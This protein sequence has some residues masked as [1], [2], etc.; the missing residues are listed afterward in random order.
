MYISKLKKAALASSAL[1][2]LY[3]PE[4]IAQNKHQVKLDAYKY[5]NAKTL[6]SCQLQSVQ[7]KLPQTVETR[8]VLHLR[9]MYRIAQY[10]QGQ[11]VVA[12][13][14]T[15]EGA[16]NNSLFLAPIQA[17]S[18]INCLS[19]GVSPCTASTRSR[20]SNADVSHQRTSPNLEGD[21][22][23]PRVSSHGVGDDAH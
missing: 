5:C 11:T 6:N 21:V 20:G 12:N 9:G 7:P 1:V 2:A 14:Q 16:Y 22:L 8:P 3:S 19:L 15:R 13:P 17:A 23:R 10:G 18:D 4:L